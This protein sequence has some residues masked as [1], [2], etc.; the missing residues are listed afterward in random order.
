VTGDQA[1]TPTQAHRRLELVT[2]ELDLVHH[3]N[4]LL[5]ALAL[6]VVV[7][8]APEGSGALLTAQSAV[9][10]GRPV[11]AVPGPLGQPGYAGS[12]RLIQQGARLVTCARD[13]LA[14]SPPP[15]ARASSRH[16]PRRW[17]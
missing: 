16:A 4:R 14:G 8:E 12:H 15:R 2:D 5:S 9:D 13:I 7:V 1:V 10:Q 11:F 6:G 17:R 3:R